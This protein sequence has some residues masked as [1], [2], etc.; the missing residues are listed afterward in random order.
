MDLRQL[1]YFVAIVRCGSISQAS[2]RLNIAQPALSLHIRNMEVD[3]GTPLLFRNPHGVQPTEAGTILFR[4]ALVILDQLELARQEIEGSAAEP[5]GEV[6]VGLPSS[7]SQVLGVPLI[8][9]ARRQAPKVALRV[10]EAMSGY[11]LDWLRQGHVDFGLLYRPVDDRGPR[12]VR[13]MGMCAQP[14]RSCRR[15][16]R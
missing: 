16:W 14:M 15:G 7:I 4:N 5:S 9:A 6:R 11:V 3:L 2:L 8:L 1:R 10:A 12:S 13:P